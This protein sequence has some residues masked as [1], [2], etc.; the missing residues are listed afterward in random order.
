MNAGTE[1]GSAVLRAGVAGAV[2][3]S[4]LTELAELSVVVLFGV[5]ALD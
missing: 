2:L 5:V 3:D 1:P 4:V